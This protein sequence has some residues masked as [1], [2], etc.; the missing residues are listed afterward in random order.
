MSRYN[1]H[2]LFR[3]EVDY[4]VNAESRDEAITKAWRELELDVPGL[5]DFE[6]DGVRLI[7]PSEMEIISDSEA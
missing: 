7:D 2:L 1:V 5:T 4:Q 6:S 3:G